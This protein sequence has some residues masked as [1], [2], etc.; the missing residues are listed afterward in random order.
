MATLSSRGIAFHSPTLPPAAA[1]RRYIRRS[2][3]STF[4][5]V[6]M[7]GFRCRDRPAG[8]CRSLMS[9]RVYCSSEIDS[10]NVTVKEKAVSVILMAGGSGKRMGG[11]IPKQY[12]P[13]LGQPIALYSLHI[14]SEMSEVKELV[15][16]CDPSYKDIFEGSPSL[17]RQR[18]SQ[19]ILNLLFLGKRDKILSTTGFRFLKMAIEL[20]LLCLVS[21]SKPPSKSYYWF[22]PTSY[23]PGRQWILCGENVRSENTMG[24]VIKP[25]LLQRGFELVNREGLK[26]TD[27]VSIVE[28]LKH[29]VY[30]TEA[31]YTNIKVTTPDELLLAEGILNMGGK[32]PKAET[33]LNMDTKVPAS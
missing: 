21:L 26:V 12:L 19:L 20:E 6:S 28:H 22:H 15:V 8:F 4:S 25:Q 2:L 11:S 7:V 5:G 17:I 1:N 29:P 18:I 27:D 16:V 31:S 23:S 10:D 14:F 9:L 13:L 24:N 32:V 33:I 30:I 3:S